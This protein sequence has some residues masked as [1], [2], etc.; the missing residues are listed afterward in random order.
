MKARLRTICCICNERITIGEEI[1]RNAAGR[2]VH[3]N[4]F[5]AV[6]TRAA[7]S[8]FFDPP[9]HEVP[10]HPRRSG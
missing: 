7:G 1:T 6:G 3:Y 5:A 9:P 4:C 8:K 2:S 10:A